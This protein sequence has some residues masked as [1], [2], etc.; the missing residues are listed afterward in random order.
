MTNLPVGPELLNSDRRTDMTKLIVAFRNF[1]N[2]HKMD[3]NSSVWVLTV[4]DMKYA[5][6]YFCDIGCAR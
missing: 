2:A 5:N 6:I 4:I 3:L 1:A